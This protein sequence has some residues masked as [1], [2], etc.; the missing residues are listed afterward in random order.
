MRVPSVPC[1]LL[2]S[3]RTDV[4]GAP[5]AMPTSPTLLLIAAAAP[6]TPV[7]CPFASVPSPLPKQLICRATLRSEC[8]LTPE[9]MMASP[10]PSHA[11]ADVALVGGRSASTVPTAGV[12]VCAAPVTTLFGEIPRTVGDTRSSATSSAVRYPVKPFTTL[13]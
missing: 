1:I 11:P 7:P 4:I 5:G 8:T 3:T 2:S 13:S 6:A 9:S 10:G 12:T